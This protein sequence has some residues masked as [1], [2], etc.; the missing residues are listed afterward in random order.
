MAT[1][2]FFI[3]FRSNAADVQR[4]MKEITN[5]QK[6]MN[7]SFGSSS[8]LSSQQRPLSQANRPINLL[9]KSHAD[10][11]L[12]Q[13]TISRQKNLVLK[14]LNEAMLAGDQITRK[15]VAKIMQN[16][17]DLASVPGKIREFVPKSHLSTAANRGKIEKSIGRI[18][19]IDID[20]IQADV[21]KLYNKF[22]NY[23]L[24]DA[25]KMETH[26]DALAQR[27]T[28]K[29]IARQEVSAQK[30]YNASQRFAQQMARKEESAQAKYNIGASGDAMSPFAPQLGMFGKFK[31]GVKGWWDS[32]I[33]SIVKNM[34][35]IYSLYAIFNKV[36]Q[37]VRYL[38]SQT[39]DL[40]LAFAR[41]NAISLTAGTNYSKLRDV[42]F[43]LGT[44][45]G[46]LAT[47]TVKA[48]H[49]LIQMGLTTEEITM[50]TDKAMK[51]AN[52][53]GESLTETLNVM[54]S[55][56]ATYNISA[57][58]GADLYAYWGSLASKLS[59]SIPMIAKGFEQAGDTFKDFGFTA[60]EVSAVMAT[61]MEG[62]RG[63]LP[64]IVR[65]LRLMM[66][67]MKDSAGDI[68][69]Y[70]GVAVLD[71]AGAV[72]PG[73]EVLQ[74]MAGAW[75][76]MTK[77]QKDN[78]T[79]GMKNKSM[80]QGL[81]E[82]M[83][84]WKDV[85]EAIRLGLIDGNKLLN[86]QSAI[87]ENTVVKQWA[88]LQNIWIDITT[89]QASGMVL[90]LTEMLGGLKSL[91]QELA[92]PNIQKLFEILLKGKESIDLGL[93]GIDY[94]KNR[95]PGAFGLGEETYYYGRSSKYAGQEIYDKQLLENIKNKEAYELAEVEKP[96]F[97][98]GT[99]MF[100]RWREARRKFL[101]EQRTKIAGATP[102]PA[103]P[104][105]LTGYGNKNS[106][107][108][109]DYFNSVQAARNWVD[110]GYGEWEKNQT[111]LNKAAEQ[112]L[113]LEQ[114][115]LQLAGGYQVGINKELQE[116]ILKRK[117]LESIIGS[118][119]ST[120]DELNKQRI[121]QE[122]RIK[123]LRTDETKSKADAESQLLNINN[124]ID[125]ETIKIEEATNALILQE[126]VT[127]KLGET[128]RNMILDTMVE[129][130][131]KTQTWLDLNYKLRDLL[132]NI[133]NNVLKNVLDKVT[134]GIADKLGG[135]GGLVAGD[136]GGKMVMG[137]DGKIMWQKQ[138]KAAGYAGAAMMGAAIGSN[139]GTAGMVGGAIGSV[140]GASV[141]GPIGAVAGG[142]LGSLF[143]KPKKDDNKAEEA[144]K[145][146]S[147]T[148]SKID[149][150][151]NE[152]QIVNRN[153]VALKEKFDP[154]PFRSSTY[155]T[156]HM[157]T[158]IG[159]G[160]WGNNITINVN[161]ANDPVTTANAVSKA[162]AG[163]SMQGAQA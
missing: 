15:Q 18:M 121:D 19:G 97:E 5:S 12:L 58:E 9:S 93:P 148:P 94:Y 45:H 153:L 41:I 37:A 122:A 146:F 88:A 80:L 17:S 3:N 95:K 86:S 84:S 4:A 149:V 13:K 92:N 2:D 32:G 161:G 62:E 21:D 54:V 20:T 125:A 120:L 143:G 110:K 1:L 160:T 40:Q 103:T 79:Q 72:R 87:I 70:M 82:V 85:D 107:A 64:G 91:S 26:K 53:T 140:I 63:R 35:G 55:V 116:E 77:A 51:V 134:G 10:E 50:L 47:E 68:F 145:S 83:N 78:L 71:A 16:M 14:G 150:T 99:D 108:T 109:T 147:S 123:L 119:G 34:A 129:I 154:Y 115:R 76:N 118:S 27:Q 133:G 30:T 31:Q 111:K 81:R 7:K 138:S 57:K 65:F 48:I 8:I 162:I 113:K 136:S 135:L 11:M 137:P 163:Y 25:V 38:V 144:L 23:Q 157:N 66:E 126:T 152:L 127:R 156:S 102:A 43:S 59:V 22:M 128:Y 106:K 49:P 46:F 96:P 6:E 114:L 104:G 28:A 74:D 75:A 89:Q 141:G 158:G 155:F 117:E 98:E 44:A 36:S 56:M 42:V 159:A 124:A 142:W 101:K 60:K 131:E 112:G 52:L 69:T 151:N 130:I 24:H 90:F 132:S 39:I 100:H 29:A 73:Y 105:D 61:L 33:G 139:R 67:N